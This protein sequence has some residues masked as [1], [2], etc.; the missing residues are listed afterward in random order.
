[1]IAEQWS[2]M[3]AVMKLVMALRTAH[4]VENANIEE[5][6]KISGISA[7]MAQQIYDHLHSIPL[8]DDRN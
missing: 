5:L 8:Q 1:M 3:I 7:T 6:Q 4:G 2:G